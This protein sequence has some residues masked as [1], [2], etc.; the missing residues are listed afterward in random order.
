VLI[1]TPTKSIFCQKHFL[2]DVSIASQEI[3][4]N[5]AYAMEKNMKIQQNLNFP[6]FSLSPYFHSRLSHGSKTKEQ[7]QSEAIECSFHLMFHSISQHTSL[8]F[9]LV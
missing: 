4:L 7:K 3:M 1:D 2:K 5:F 6:T 9:E 8:K